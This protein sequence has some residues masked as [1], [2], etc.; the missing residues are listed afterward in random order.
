MSFDPIDFLEAAVDTPSHESVE[1]MRS[2]LVETLEVEGVRV[3]VDDAG[4]VLAERGRENVLSE[5]GGGA[6]RVVLNTHI[7]TVAPHVPCERTADTIRGRGSCDA[8]GPLASMID[9]FLAVEPADGSIVLAVTPDE[10]AT[11]SG[12]AALDLEPDAF[13]VGEPTGLDVCTAARGRFQGTVTVTGTGA[14][15]ADPDSGVNA[16]SAVSPILDGFDSYDDERRPDRHS[17]L[18]SPTLT[19]T[20][21]DGGE[22]TNRVP[23]EVVITFDRRSVPPEGAEEFFETFERHLHTLVP[24]EVEVSVSPADRETPFLEAFETNDDEPVVRALVDAGAGNV[25]PFGAAT[26]AS[27]FSKRA[28]TVVFGPGDL[29]DDDGPVAHSDREY[30]RIESV[31]RAASILRTALGELVD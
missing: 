5:Q 3:R 4:N 15:A 25:R 11:S 13:V 1:A 21:I 14:H 12:A 10:E 26:E 22:A 30:V 23:S 17:R 16:I 18:G 31:R 29:S 28:P 6:P 7:D 8:K 27:Y 2:L 19:P 20:R 24:T 9:A